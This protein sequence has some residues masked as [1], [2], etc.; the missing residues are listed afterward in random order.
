MSAHRSSYRQLADENSYAAIKTYE[1]EIS[2]RKMYFLPK[3]NLHLYA[4]SIKNG[5]LIGITTNI[6]GL[7]ISHTGIAV[8]MDN[9]SLHLMHAP[10]VGEKVQITQATLHD[11]LA[12]NPRQ[13]GI[14]VAEALE[15]K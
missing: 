8:R 4:D 9:G 15:P 6:S 2:T 10:D 13:T 7:D 14:V 5:S 12:R 3:G 11:Y 1:E